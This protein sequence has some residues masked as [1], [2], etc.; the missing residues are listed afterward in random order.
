MITSYSNIFTDPFYRFVLGSKT[1]LEEA[2]LRPGGQP[3]VNRTTVSPTGQVSQ[4]ST[5]VNAEKRGELL[6]ALP[7]TVSAERAKVLTAPATAP[8]RK[9]GDRRSVPRPERDPRMPKDAKD[10]AVAPGQERRTG[11]PVESFITEVKAFFMTPA[12]IVT[13][14]LVGV[15]LVASA[16]RRRRPAG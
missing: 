5:P 4:T 7:T 12:G 8:Q 6:P 10:T 11:G 14:A 15:V 2:T 9:G 16:A 3:V 1:V 13:L